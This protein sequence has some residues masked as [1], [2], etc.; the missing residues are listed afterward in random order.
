MKKNTHH[1]MYTFC[2]LESWVHTNYFTKHSTLKCVDSRE[3]RLCQF[4]LV[5]G[6]HRNTWR[7]CEAH[8]VRSQSRAVNIWVFF[9]GKNPQPRPS[10][11]IWEDLRKWGSNPLKL[12][13]P[14]AFRSHWNWPSDSIREMRRDGDA[15]FFFFVN[16]SVNGIYPQAK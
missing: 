7:P 1:Y 2:H 15:C 5:L 8:H 6:F 11:K 3:S 13:V 9:T 14:Q 12:G 16:P 10:T 4:L